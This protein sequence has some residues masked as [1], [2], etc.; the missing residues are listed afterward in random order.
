MMEE[1]YQIK[2]LYNMQ[3]INGKI[4]RQVL[5]NNYVKVDLSNYKNNYQNHYCINRKNWM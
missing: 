2:I 5:K 4:F 1:V 3:K